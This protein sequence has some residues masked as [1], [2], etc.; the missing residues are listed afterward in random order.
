[1]NTLIDNTT[2]TFYGT[3]WNK[4]TVI[5]A[6]QSEAD[7]ETIFVINDGKKRTE[8]KYR[9]VGDK[10]AEA[11]IQFSGETYNHETNRTNGF[12]F[13]IPLEMADIFMKGLVYK[14]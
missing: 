7:R 1:M 6:Y 13:S 8:V 5:E 2:K 10:N 14:K 9:N 12:S 4:G 11:S 3:G